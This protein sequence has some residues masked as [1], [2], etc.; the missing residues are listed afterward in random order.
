[1]AMRGYWQ[2]G[3]IALALL[4]L[5]IGIP[6]AVFGPGYLRHRNEA[7]LRTDGLPAMARILELEDTGSRFN[8]SPEMIVRVQVTRDGTAPW[9][10]SFRR[11]FEVQDVQ[12]FTPGHS[13]PVRYDP[14]RPTVVAYA[15]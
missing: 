12:F 4:T 15:P 8:A 11:V 2:L 5:V 6:A 9:E 1:M 3:L 14:A 10:A 7:R 13:I